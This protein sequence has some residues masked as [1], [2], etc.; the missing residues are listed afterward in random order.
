MVHVDV[1]QREFLRHVLLN[2][3]DIIKVV[4]AYRTALSLVI[5]TNLWQ[6][7]IALKQNRL[8]IGLELGTVLENIVPIR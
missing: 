1:A 4:G 3:L 2:L 7:N 6:R 8:V 5:A